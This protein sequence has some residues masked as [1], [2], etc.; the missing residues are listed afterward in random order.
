[1]ERRG[2]ALGDVLSRNL[3]GGTRDNHDGAEIQTG[4]L[5][6]NQF[7]ALPP[8]PACFAKY[9]R[10]YEYERTYDVEDLVYFMAAFRYLP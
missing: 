9:E 6:E 7:E 8:E 1:M 5:P 3:P 2:R 4:Y 10:S